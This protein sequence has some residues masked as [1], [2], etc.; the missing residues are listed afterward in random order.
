[1]PK[2]TI[3]I[4]AMLTALGAGMGAAGCGRTGQPAPDVWAVVNGQ[5]IHRAEAEKYYDN[6]LRDQGQG[7]Q[8]APPQSQEEA[9]TL[10]LNI[11][12]EL[13]N[14]AILVQRAQKLGV[15][16]TDGEVEDKFTEF[17]SPY[18]EEEFQRQLKDRGVSV[19]DLKAD[20]RQQLSVQKLINR[21]VIAKISISDKDVSDFYAQY[22]S[23][24]NVP[25]AQYR[26][27]QIVVTPAKDPQVRNRK[28]DDAT[29]DVEAR[30][31]AAALLQ[32]LEKGS[33]FTQVAMDYSEDPV[34]TASGG[35][36]G[37]V[38]ESALNQSNPALKKAVL[39]LKPGETS[40]VIALPDGYRILKL[41]AK[42]AP[43]QR[44]I[45][46][47][48]VQQSIRDTL[49]NRE[50]QVLR[51]AYM[52]AARDDSKVVNFLAQQVLESTGKLPQIMKPGAA[53][54]AAPPAAP[55]P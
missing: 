9:L 17:K 14:N 50:E 7:Q 3:A 25:E 31:K 46:D 41:V 13:V 48:Q 55:Q 4:A 51:S 2:R 39:G 10:M 44:D 32:Q 40:A 42:E 27:S 30:R 19:D 12:D 34:S 35:D 1:M 15:Q 37:Y 45:N 20:I 36:L 16:A 8:T 38:P 54:A 26:L 22:R 24:F 47:P 21:E 23:Q 11:M 28:S 43:G 52:A 29:S 6:R 18:T 5:Q 33:D 53:P 49:R